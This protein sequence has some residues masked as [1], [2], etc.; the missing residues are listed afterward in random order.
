MDT[1]FWTTFWTPFLTGFWRFGRHLRSPREKRGS[2]NGPKRVKT[3]LTREMY[4]HERCYVVFFWRFLTH[5]WPFFDGFFQ[6]FD[7]DR[8]KIRRWLR[9][10][11][12]V[13]F[14]RKKRWK[15]HDLPRN[16]LKNLTSENGIFGQKRSKTVQKPTRKND[17]FDEF[18]PLKLNSPKT[19]FFGSER[20][21][22]VKNGQKLVPNP[23]DFEKWW[24]LMKSF[25]F[26]EKCRKCR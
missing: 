14:G 25:K 24:F 12:T 19:G 6:N 13:N 4:S 11:K 17:R 22:I 3:G 9:K 18:C 26:F 16:A 8:Q 21:K 20:L 1:P 5:F 10:L 7:A 23:D 2:K 15:K